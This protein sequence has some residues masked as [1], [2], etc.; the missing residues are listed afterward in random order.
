MVWKTEMYFSPLWRLEVQDQGIRRT[1]FILSLLLL[2]C[3]WPPSHPCSHNLFVHRE[4]N[5][6]LPLLTRHRSYGIQAPPIPP[7]LMVTISIRALFPNTVTLR[8]GLQLMNLGG[9]D[10]V[11]NWLQKENVQAPCKGCCCWARTSPA[12]PETWTG[13][14]KDVYLGKQQLSWESQHWPKAK[15]PKQLRRTP[16]DFH[17]NT[18]RRE[19][20]FPHWCL[21]LTDSS[22]PSLSICSVPGPVVR[23]P[24]YWSI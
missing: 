2:A 20:H 13:R 1:G 8:L 9:Q 10:S 21:M 23:L 5:P 17:R 24:M 14:D 11:P 3:M 12:E 16:G 19:S 6:S 22:K 18:G 15:D 7:H 4:K